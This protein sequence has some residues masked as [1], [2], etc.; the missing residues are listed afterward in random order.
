MPL[1]YVYYTF[2][3]FCRRWCI[4]ILLLFYDSFLNI[5]YHVR[6]SS[7]NQFLLEQGW[8]ISALQLWWNCKSHHASVSRSHACDCQGLAM[9]HGTCSF[10]TGG[11][12]LSTPGLGTGSK[13]FQCLLKL[14]KC[15]WLFELV[16]LVNHMLIKLKIF[17]RDY[18]L[19]F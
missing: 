8:A 2:N 13:L 12:R 5:S 19:F 11:P 4:S 10:R 7:K 17:A 9:S 14:T 6:T 1:E 16:L 15:P 18:F 3:M